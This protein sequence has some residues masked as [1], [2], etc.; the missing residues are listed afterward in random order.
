[1][2]KYFS[3][4]FLATTPLSLSQTL[5]GLFELTWRPSRSLILPCVML[6]EL[7][8]NNDTFRCPTLGM[9]VSGHCPNSWRKPW[10]CLCWKKHF[11]HRSIILKSQENRIKFVTRLGTPQRFPPLQ[12]PEPASPKSRRRWRSRYLPNY[13]N[14]YQFASIYRQKMAGPNWTSIQLPSR[15]LYAMLALGIFAKTCIKVKRNL[16]SGHSQRSLS[17]KIL[18][19]S[20]QRFF[21]FTRHPDHLWPNQ[22]ILDAIRYQ[23]KDLD[24]VFP[25]MPHNLV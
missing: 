13:Q 19:P 15:A 8:R 17:M 24:I 12:P 23:M 10:L 18:L 2:G 16:G 6:L 9:E 14:H 7:Q 11:F 4:L 3:L 1:M 22:K 25:L 20:V 5:Q 21:S